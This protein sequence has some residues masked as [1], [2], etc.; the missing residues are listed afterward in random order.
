M[1][2]PLG[3]PHPECQEEVKALIFPRGQSFKKYFGACNDRKVALDWCFKKEKHNKRAKNLQTRKFNEKWEKIQAENSKK[4]KY[5][6]SNGPQT[7][8]R[9]SLNTCSV[10]IL[11][12][13][14]TFT[15]LMGLHCTVWNII[16]RLTM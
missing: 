11:P 3:R 13:N 4:K 9:G 16:F 15:K 5:L 7:Q 12:C 2:P 1:H 14:S 10:L 6:R 8:R